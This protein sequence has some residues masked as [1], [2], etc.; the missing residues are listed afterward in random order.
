[1]VDSTKDIEG[2][3]EKEEKEYIE[4]SKNLPLSTIPGSITSILFDYAS[5]FFERSPITMRSSHAQ[6]FLSK[7]EVMG[8]NLQNAIGMLGSSIS[9]ENLKEAFGEA[10]NPPY[11]TLIPDP[12]SRG[13]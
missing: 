7:S 8:H 13:E 9:F 2:I 6:P 12:K 1:M 10:T 5:G 3:M 4:H 11:K